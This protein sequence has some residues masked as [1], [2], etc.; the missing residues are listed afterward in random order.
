L[1]EAYPALLMPI[2]VTRAKNLEHAIAITAAL[3]NLGANPS[4]VVTG[5]PDPH[6]PDSAAYFH[7]LL[8]LRKAK[9]VDQEVRFVYESGP[10]PGKPFLIPA[11]V[12]WDLMRVCDAILMTSHNEG[13]GMPV[14]EAGLAGVPV[15]TSPN[16]PAAFEI[17]AKETLVYPEDASP[18]EI[19]SQIIS[20]LDSIPTARLRR[21][22]KRDF[23]WENLF[24][25]QIK[26]LLRLTEPGH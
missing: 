7:Q 19:A 10:E 21:K 15:I 20:W 9:G 11:S 2:R 17:A 16:I 8:D 25:Q 6:N 14:L 26:P 4:V 5:P 22:V 12:V 3:K 1:L 13:F 24:D 23:V 18:E